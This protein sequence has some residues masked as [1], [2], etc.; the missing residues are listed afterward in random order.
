MTGEQPMNL[1]EMQNV[2]I[3]TV[4]PDTLV[5]IRDVKRSGVLAKREE[6]F[7]DYIRQMKNPYL[8]KYKKM[9]VKDNFIETQDSLEDKL[10]ELLLSL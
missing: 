4:N 9:I 1:Y 7:L 6:R 3:R 5:D 8:Y 2:D 10:E